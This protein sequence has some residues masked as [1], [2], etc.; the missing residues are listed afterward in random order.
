MALN[1]SGKHTEKSSAGI[2]SS[3]NDATAREAENHLKVAGDAAKILDLNKA[4]SEASAAIAL[5]PQNFEAYMLRGCAYD[6]DNQ[7]EKAR[8]DFEHAVQLN[9]KDNEPLVRIAKSY[10]YDKKYDLA[11][12]YYSKAVAISGDNDSWVGR[13]ETYLLAGKAKESLDDAEKAL[14]IDPKDERAMVA[15]A[16]ANIA[17]GQPAK[18]L[19]D[20]NFAIRV[21]PE[22][23]AYR[24]A[25]AKA[26][27]KLGEETLAASDRKMVEAQVKH[28][29]DVA[30]FRAKKGDEQSHW[31]RQLLPS[32]HLRPR[33]HQDRQ[34]GG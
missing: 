23:R 9:G 4:I 26:Y 22:E 5:N 16:N 1:T 6:D 24:L 7:M 32:A 29:Y 8:A 34:S 20:L 15:R 21:K 31:R 14:K 11:L 27:E 17:L 3:K 19:P 30:P 2:V 25:R 12:K 10:V 13:S 33:E 28:Y 18:A